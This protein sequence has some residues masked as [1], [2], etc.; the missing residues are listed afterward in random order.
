M[1]RAHSRRA[2]AGAPEH[3]R[4]RGVLEEGW[5]S[6]VSSPSTIL[7]SRPVA[8]ADVDVVVKLKQIIAVEKGGKSKTHQDLAATHHG[9]QRH[10]LPAGISR[11]YQPK[12]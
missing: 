12:D 11:T 8:A 3:V 4:L 7:R 6:P 5:G 1:W 2:H 10:A 9:L